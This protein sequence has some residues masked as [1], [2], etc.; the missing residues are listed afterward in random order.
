MDFDNKMATKIGETTTT[1]KDV[2]FIFF[3]Q[4]RLSRDT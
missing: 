3:G 2:Q 1:F 4:N